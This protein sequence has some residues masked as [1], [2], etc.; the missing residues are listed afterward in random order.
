MDAINQM[1]LYSKE[2]TPFF[3]LFDFELNHPHV[4]PLNQ[5]ITRNI[6]FD[7][8]GLNNGH[9]STTGAP[10]WLEPVPFPEEIYLGKFQAALH[11]LKRGDAYLLNLT[12]KTQIRTTAS[13][14]EIFLTARS[15]YKI[16]Y[17][18]QF[19]CF[20]P[21]TF[22]TI[23]DNVIS[24][25]PMKGTIRDQ[26]DAL[27]KITSNNKELAEHITVVDL[28][29]NDLAQVADNVTVPEFRFPTKINSSHYNLLQISS[30]I[31]GFLQPHYK[32]NFGDLFMALLPAGSVSGAPKKK[33]TQLIKSIEGETRGYYCGVAG[34]FDGHR[35]ESCV[36]IRYIELH[37]NLFWY[38]SGGGITAASNWKEEYQELID[39]IYVPT[40]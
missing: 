17:D 26:A 20:S 8:N 18:N 35:L 6:F 12:S 29:R 37:D 3:F 23:E 11:H 31:S 24:T 32:K 1:N 28:L 5:T 27:G 4:I 16:L 13:L 19:V 15:R 22:I 36:L 14:R 10:I 2:K 39:K 33:V 21:E 34:A 9:H 40:V 7:F 30:R 38:R 25:F